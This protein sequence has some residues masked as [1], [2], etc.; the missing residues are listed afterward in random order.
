MTS[1]ESRINR[2]R[3]HARAIRL[4]MGGELRAARMA[5]GLSQLGAG[6]A[7]GMSHAQFG[8]I[9]RGDLRHLTVEQL[10]RA[11]AAVG[12]KLA[13]RAFPD[14]DPVRD[15][16]QLALLHRFR[17]LLPAGAVWR[18]EVPLPIV[19]D[20]RAWDGF[21]TLQ[22]TFM[23]VEAESRLR[24]VQALERR[25]SLKLRDGGVARLVV[26]VADTRSNRQ[27]IAAHREALR[28]LLPLDRREMIRALR[29]GRIPDASGLLL[30]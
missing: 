14:G 16:G 7:V 26:V 15:A 27:A 21:V 10:S 9:E 24:D 3:A 1:R 17:A 23:A 12:L 18:T 11:C 22:G 20:R 30:L 6:T 25:L 28:S 19:G 2:A 4:T 29:S 8:R 13:V 5:S